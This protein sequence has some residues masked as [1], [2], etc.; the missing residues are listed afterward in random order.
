[1]KFQCTKYAR[2]IAIVL[3]VL[4]GCWGCLLHSWAGPGYSVDIQVSDGAVRDR[5]DVELLEKELMEE[6]FIK[7]TVNTSGSITCLVGFKSFAQPIE[8][9]LTD[10]VPWLLCFAAV[11]SGPGI[12]DLCFRIYDDRRGQSPAVKDEIDRVAEVVYQKWSTRF[13]KENITVAG[14]RTGPPF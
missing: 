10:G 12:S 13:G 3:L 11:K 14:F 7:K 6:G 4:C 9:A 5:K 1:M 2:H 8:D